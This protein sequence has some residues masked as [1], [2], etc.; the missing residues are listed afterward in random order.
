M[1]FESWASAEF[2]L[3]PTELDELHLVAAFDIFVS[4]CE[5]ARRRGAP[6]PL[7]TASPKRAGGNSRTVTRRMLAQL[8]YSRPQLRVI[9]R[10]LAGSTGGWPGLLALFVSKRPPTT[11]QRQYALRQTKLF[12]EASEQI[13]SHA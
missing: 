8:G 7:T 13:S 9:H 1:T 12:H 5:A 11:E 6:V 10:L 2:H 4:R 3:A